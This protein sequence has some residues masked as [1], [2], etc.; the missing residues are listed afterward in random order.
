MALPPNNELKADLCAPRWELTR[1]GIKIESKDDIRA[2]IGRS[3]AR[4]T[5][6]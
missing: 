3:P 5:S 6:S 1:Q 4:A 2:R